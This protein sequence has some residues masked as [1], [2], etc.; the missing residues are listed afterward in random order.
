[1]N[2]FKNLFFWVICCTF[3]PHAAKA[4]NKK[5]WYLKNQQEVATTD[6]TDH[7]TAPKAV[8]TNQKDHHPHLQENH[9]AKA[10][11]QMVKKVSR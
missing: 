1:L 5:I 9:L 10:A 8:V 6:Q 3:D 11:A 4:Q 7:Q 2:R